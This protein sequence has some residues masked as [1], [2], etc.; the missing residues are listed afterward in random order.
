M[1]STHARK[2]HKETFFLMHTGR[3]PARLPM[4]VKSF[5]PF[6][7]PNENPCPATHLASCFP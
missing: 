7:Q 5:I 2:F 1:L 6:A 4:L 3:F